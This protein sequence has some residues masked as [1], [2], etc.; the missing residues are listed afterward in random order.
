MVIKYVIQIDSK[1]RCIILLGVLD[2]LNWLGN[3]PWSSF[4]DQQEFILREY[5]AIPTR[6]FQIPHLTIFRG[7]ATYSSV[8]AHA[9]TPK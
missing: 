6:G 7:G 2:Q 9:P 1:Y 5:I 4:T 3:S 8:D